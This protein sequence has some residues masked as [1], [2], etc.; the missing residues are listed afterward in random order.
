MKDKYTQCLIIKQ[1]DDVTTTI[2][3][4]IPSK[5]AVDGRRIKLMRNDKWE[6]GWVVEKS[7]KSSE[8]EAPP[9]YQK[10]VREHKRRTGDSLPKEKH[11]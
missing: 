10:A 11:V 8:R 6:E 3:S 5:L 9:D 4:Y 2:V 1:I 7:Y